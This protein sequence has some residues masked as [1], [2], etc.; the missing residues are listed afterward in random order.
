MHPAPMHRESWLDLQEL[1]WVSLRLGRVCL[2]VQRCLCCAST[3][4]TRTPTTWCRSHIHKYSPNQKKKLNIF[5]KT[6]PYLLHF[7]PK[8]AVHTFSSALQW[9]RLNAA[10][11]AASQLCLW[12]LQ[13]EKFG[14]L[15]RNQPGRASPDCSSMPQLEIG[16]CSHIAAVQGSLSSVHM[17]D[18]QKMGHWGKH[19]C[20][21]DLSAKCPI[22]S[23]KYS[24]LKPMIYFRELCQ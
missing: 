3:Q 21:S 16:S 8:K 5:V 4:V 11:R 9:H 24:P 19:S 6:I 14:T 13:Q 2:F 18:I 15:P 12:A 22:K 1:H 17:L 10:D 23:W 7:M 20:H